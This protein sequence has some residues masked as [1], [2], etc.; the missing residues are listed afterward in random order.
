[1]PL[2]IAVPTWYNDDSYINEK[3]DEC[4]T[5]KFGA[6]EG[7]EFTPWT[8]ASVRDFLAAANGEADYQPWMGY[9]N[10]VSNGNA[11]NCSPN[12][13]FN[14][15]QYVTAKAAQ[16]N[17]IN[18]DGR[19]AD[20]NPWTAQNVL[21]F[22]NAHDITAWDHFTTAGQF[23]N[24]NPSNAMDLS[25]FLASK[26]K[27]CND[28]E[29]DGRNDWD[30]QAVLDYYQQHGLNAVMVAVSASDPNVVAVPEAEQVTPPVGF[31]P[32]G[33]AVMPVDVELTTGVDVMPENEAPINYIG[34]VVNTNSSST[35]NPNDQINGGN[36]AD[37]LTV[38]M[39]RSWIGFNDGFVKDVPTVN[40]NNETASGRNL[41][42]N[43][44]NIEG[45]DT[46]NVNGNVSLSNLEKAGITVNLSNVNGDNP[47]NLNFD[48]DAVK[49]GNDSLTLG[50]NNMPEYVTVNGNGIEHVTVNSTGDVENYV[51]LKGMDGAKSV[52]IT[53]DGE[54]NVALSPTVT[55]IDATE[56]GA[57][58]FVCTRYSDLVESIRMGKGDDSF[59]LRSI[60]PNAVVDG[61]D[62]QDTGKLYNTSGAYQLQMSNVETLNITVGKNY[63]GQA[64]PD[65]TAALSLDGG[66]T[67]GLETL[68]L[69]GGNGYA[70]DGT[71]A[72]AR[73]ISLSN[74]DVGELNVA[75]TKQ[76]NVDLNI[77]GIEEITVNVGDGKATDTANNV[78]LDQLTGTVTLPDAQ[79][80]AINIADINNP[81]NA[82]TEFDAALVAGKA[83]SLSLTSGQNAGIQIQGG[84]LS[85]VSQLTISGYYNTTIQNANLSQ[86][87]KSV[88][89][90][91]QGQIGGTVTTSFTGN[92]TNGGATL[93]YD[94]STTGENDLTV[95]NTYSA[96]NVV[97]GIN[98]DT[99]TLDAGTGFKYTQQNL[100]GNL[101]SGDDIIVVKGTVDAGSDFT[102]LA[103]V[104]TIKFEGMSRQAAQ[105][106]VADHN[107]KIGNAVAVDGDYIDK[108]DVPI[109]AG[110]SGEIY[111]LGGD[112]TFQGV[113][114]TPDDMTLNG[115]TE[116]GEEGK[117][118]A[119]FGNGEGKLDV[120]TV[121]NLTLNG[122]TLGA[123]I[124]GT[125]A[126]GK[127]Q[128]NLTI[129]NTASTV[130]D[131]IGAA[132]TALTVAATG[133]VAVTGNDVAES[134][135]NLKVTQG[136]TA[137]IDSGAANGATVE[138]AGVAGNVDV[139]TGAGNDTVT[140]AVPDQ[141]NL[142]VSTGAGNDA[143]NV[144]SAVQAQAPAARA[145]GQTL[146]FDGGEGADTVTFQDDANLT[147][148]GD[149]IF[150][151]IETVG[152]DKTFTVDANQLGG[153]SIT[154]GENATK[155]T[156]N[157]NITDMLDLSGVD[158][159]TTEVT[160]GKGAQVTLGDAAD[161][162]VLGSGVDTPDALNVVIGSFAAG[163]AAGHDNISLDGFY[164]DFGFGTSVDY[165]NHASGSA[166]DGSN[167]AGTGEGS[168]ASYDWEYTVA[169]DGGSAITLQASM[170]VTY[171]SLGSDNKI[172][173]LDS[174]IVAENSAAVADIFQGSSVGVITESATAGATSAA[175]EFD[176]GDNKGLYLAD[177]SDAIV[178][179][180]NADGGTNLWYVSNGSTQGV[181]DL[182]VQ[183][184][185]T[186]DGITNPTTLVSA[187]F[188]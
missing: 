135:F 148:W 52:K 36:A 33:V 101:G 149:A 89:V 29:F 156:I 178:G 103:G 48:A 20:N 118:I 91:A 66:L 179:I 26:A 22:F 2:D 23:E 68:G 30:E 177:G 15:M 107:I 171:Q 16:L 144:N 117:L 9:A 160:M 64:T 8:A 76:N 50:I 6:V 70:L 152:Y 88:Y 38:N 14:V 112:Q 141:G 92:E 114:N 127:V 49:G 124:T 47:Y 128:G 174:G 63:A 180:N 28:I 105:K 150:T 121:Q 165:A 158:K 41:N 186:L 13:L 24:V 21:D 7:E 187:N 147:G 151:G 120:Q 168:N 162:I 172:Y 139:T 3:V 181:D 143:I 12:P 122:G 5:I 111:G 60:T 18:Y 94:G 72:A 4:N 35:L 140:V 93:N 126:S 54:A 132:G 10:F 59:T 119:N 157:D 97:T 185:G 183:L 113:I 167:A 42:F 125:I 86:N 19:N 133:G 108:N 37:E 98:S 170:N 11:E 164:S 163:S 109:V 145:A 137:T 176:S 129:D 51:W 159:G 153:A 90:D 84:D 95:D 87:A 32:W 44:E 100:T 155:L 61:G 65:P 146:S 106:Y 184:I 46:W 81:G 34:T 75:V 99:L 31:T 80:V 82:K 27:E 62:G 77:T 131:A 39:D 43:A 45:V 25:D 74:Y 136:A 166:S 57:D 83:G 110:D 115:D 188:A 161:T 182:T 58:T 67:T 69:T 175:V 134:V 55:T 116:N 96:I 104:E 102:G 53:G 154:S 85:A 130:A 1:M 123:A 78:P 17:S 73:S 169:T 138:V 142:E 71:V 40:L 79:N 173:V 56:A